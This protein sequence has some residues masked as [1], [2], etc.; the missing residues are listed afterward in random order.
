MICY[1]LEH[2]RGDKVS[3]YLHFQ[4]YELGRKFT[5]TTIIQLYFGVK[6]ALDNL[7]SIAF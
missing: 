6:N 4:G 1:R 7:C 5:A 2:E 3:G